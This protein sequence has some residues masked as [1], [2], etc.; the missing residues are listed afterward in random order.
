MVTVCF[1]LFLITLMV[2]QW[3]QRTPNALINYFMLDLAIYTLFVLNRGWKH[4]SLQIMMFVYVCSTW[5]IVELKTSYEM[6]ITRNDVNGVSL[7]NLYYLITL[8]AYLYSQQ[9][10]NVQ[11]KCFLF[12]WS[13]YRLFMLNTGWKRDSVQMKKFVNICATCA[14][15]QL[16]TRFETSITRNDV[17]GVSLITFLI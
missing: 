2:Y 6:W 14:L 9:T 8:M 15:V 10:P 13:I 17:N 16:K 3:S 1:P 11:I 7:F 4:D 12:H 5:S